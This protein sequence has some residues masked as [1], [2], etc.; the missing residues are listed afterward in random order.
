[1]K[2]NEKE[3]CRSFSVNYNLAIFTKQT[4]QKLYILQRHHQNQ[5]TP[6]RTRLRMSKMSREVYSVSNT[7]F[8]LSLLQ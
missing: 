7:Q 2:V 3:S 5:R 1:M 6:H 8:K 4:T